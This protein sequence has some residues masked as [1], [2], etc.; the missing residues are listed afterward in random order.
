MNARGL[1]SKPPTA[2]SGPHGTI[3]S[4]P[5]PAATSRIGPVEEGIARGEDHRDIPVHEPER[6][7]V[8][9]VELRA[10][11]HEHHFQG[12]ALQAPGG[13]DL[14]H[15]VLE[16]VEDRP[17]V[18]R[19]AAGRRHRHTDPHGFRSLSGRGRRRRTRGLGGGGC[20]GDP[21]E[22][23]LPGGAGRRDRSCGI[24]GARRGNKDRRRQ[25]HRDPE[26]AAHATEVRPEGSVPVAYRMSRP[27]R[28]P[29][30][31]GGSAGDE[32]AQ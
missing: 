19:L 31:K 17:V 30:R 22:R 11:V 1:P 4:T 2:G 28:S 20:R 32:G 27:G 7:L 14:A 10:G 16:R 21:I 18:G 3:T 24:G 6:R 26:A 13:V 29:G 8:A 12:P 23:R 5:A 15:R 25:N 9:A